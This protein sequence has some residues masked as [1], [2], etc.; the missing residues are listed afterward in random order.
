MLWL[1]V[2]VCLCFSGTS[3]QSF[4]VLDYGARGDGVT[5]DTAAI[6]KAV[7]A[8]EMAG[9]GILLFPAGRY[10]TAPFN[11]TSNI[12]VH[13]SPSA[14]ILGSNDLP[15]WPVIPALPSYCQGRELPGP[16]Y[17]SL[18]HAEHKNNITI[19]GGGTVDG[20][21]LKW[22]TLHRADLLSYTRGGLIEIMYMKHFVISNVT[23]L[24]APFWTVHPY[25]CDDV[26]ISNVKI[27][28][29]SDSP[30]TDG[31]D[32]DSATNVVITDCDISVGDDVIAIKSG[33]DYCGREYHKPCENITITNCV[34]GT[35]HGISI[36]SEMSGG[37][38]NVLVKDCLVRGTQAGP[39]IKT[40][41]GRG[42]VVEN[43]QFINITISGPGVVNAIQVNMF[44]DKNTVPPT[45]A[46]ATPIFR[47]VSFKDIRGNATNAGE[48]LC[49]P[50]SPCEG[51]SLQNIDISYTRA[52]FN[53]SSIFGTVINVKP[54]VC[55]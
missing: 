44:Y 14:T 13:I 6:V 40:Q 12:I 43:I 33:I 24:N 15:D 8:I 53:C 30:N 38:R 10:L 42:G 9:G 17:T 22:W 5:K 31:I 29:P 3:G 32:P 21:G 25:D 4:N 37:V 51:F 18:I 34:F 19:T 2:C 35:G 11:L 23:L 47:N 41:R 46:T 45:N 28:S 20:Q 16:R 27:Y 54:T 50:E 52:G 49:L 39:R 48:F 7:A 36:G 26:K 55:F 1:L